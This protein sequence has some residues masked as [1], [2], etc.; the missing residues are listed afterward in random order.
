MRFEIRVAGDWTPAVA[1]RFADVTAVTEPGY[2]RLTADLDQA[3]LH[4]L[5]ERVRSL[6]LELIDVRRTRPSRRR[7]RI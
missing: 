2:T 5:L 4:G 1:E 3:A 6:G 7:D